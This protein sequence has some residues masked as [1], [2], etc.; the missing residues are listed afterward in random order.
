MVRAASVVSFF[1]V[2][3]TTSKAGSRLWPNVKR[4]RG[5]SDSDDGQFRVD[6]MLLRA[7]RG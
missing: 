5:R 3:R 2:D 6:V 4:R 7:F 1:N